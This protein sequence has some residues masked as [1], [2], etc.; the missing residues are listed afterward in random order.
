M[1]W[2]PFV[3]RLPSVASFSNTVTAR[4]G[5]LVLFLVSIIIKECEAWTVKCERLERE[6]EMGKPTSCFKLLSC[7]GDATEKDDY[8]VSE[9]RYPNVS[10]VNFD[11]RHIYSTRY[12]LCLTPI[13]CVHAIRGSLSSCDKINEPG[14][15]FAS[16]IDQLVGSNKILF[17]FSLIRVF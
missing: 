17:L 4:K 15:S 16:C 13:W 1:C 7:G 9:V 5:G 12:L 6:R 11:W 3:L 2:G 8:Q 14:L 10:K